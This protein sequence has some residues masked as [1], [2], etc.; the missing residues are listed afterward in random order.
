MPITQI[1]RRYFATNFFVLDSS[2]S[3]KYIALIP[4]C[5][6]RAPEISPQIRVLEYA[7][8]ILRFFAM[9]NIW[10]AVSHLFRAPELIYLARCLLRS[11]SKC[12]PKPARVYL[13]P[14]AFR[15]H[16]ESVLTSYMQ[17][18]SAFSCIFLSD[19]PQL[20]RRRGRSSCLSWREKTDLSF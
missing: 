3:H 4:R 6:S 14:I 18:R 5:S 1:S 19:F 7:E 8:K 13:V 16:E 10:H 9:F 12:G 20:R 2:K 17:A 11:L 15:K